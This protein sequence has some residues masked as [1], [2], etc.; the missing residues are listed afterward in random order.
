VKVDL[1]SIADV[2]DAVVGDIEIEEPLPSTSARA[3]VR[4]P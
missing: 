3:I 1:A 2:F 4:L